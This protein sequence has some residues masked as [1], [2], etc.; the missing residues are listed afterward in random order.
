M[1]PLINK[2]QCWS[3]FQNTKAID[4]SITDYA[5]SQGV[6]MQILYRWYHC[7]RRRDVSQASSRMVFTQVVGTAPSSQHYYSH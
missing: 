5:R 7:L 2:Q 6:S 1:S 4:G 3:T